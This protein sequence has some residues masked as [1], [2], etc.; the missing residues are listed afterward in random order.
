APVRFTMK[1]IWTP[2][3]V[4]TI[5]LVCNSITYAQDG[6]YSI[7][8][9]NIRYNNPGDGPN[10]WPNRKDLVAGQIAR[11]NPSV[12]CL[13]EVLKDQLD[14]LTALLPDYSYTGLGRDDGKEKGEYVPIFFKKELFSLIR[15]DHFWLSE[16]PSVPG[17]LGWDAVCPRMVTWVCLQDRQTGDTLFVF[18]THF[19]HVGKQAR[20]LSAKL[21]ATFADSLA[22]NHSQIIAGDFNSLPSGE[23]YEKLVEFSYRDSRTDSQK[24]PIGPEY[25][26]TGFDSTKPPGGR[27]DYLFTKNIPK[28]ISYQVFDDRSGIYYHSDHLMVAIRF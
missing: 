18:N 7:A 4:I 19:D 23:A 10:A 12:I 9:W 6:K 13:Q 25:T 22:G 27:I 21:I 5:G 28:I 3:L 2:I 26:F 17:I 16:Q 15:T 8:T 20:K 24:A 14:D 11:E 1:T